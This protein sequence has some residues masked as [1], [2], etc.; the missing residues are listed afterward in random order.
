MK[1]K[2]SKD[3][4]FLSINLLLIIVVGLYYFI[5]NKSEYILN[6]PS[7]DS[8][9]RIEIYKNENKIFVVKDKDIEKTINL[10]IFLL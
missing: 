9:E 5:K 2:I 8:I 4:I 1:K 3:I 10:L 7:L 6:L